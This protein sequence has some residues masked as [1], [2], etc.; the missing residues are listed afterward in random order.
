[1]ALAVV[2]ISDPSPALSTRAQEVALIARACDLAAQAICSAGGASAS[3]NVTDT[4][5]VVI[6]SYVYTAVAAS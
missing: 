4:G 6:A 2:T 1:M 5:G 3:G